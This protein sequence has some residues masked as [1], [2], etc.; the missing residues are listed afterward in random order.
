[1]LK[2]N[3][4]CDH[5]LIVLGSGQH[6]IPKCAYKGRMDLVCVQIADGVTYIDDCAFEDCRFLS[7]IVI[8]SSVEHISETAFKNCGS[9]FWQIFHSSKVEFLGHSDC[10]PQMGCYRAWTEVSAQDW[11]WLLRDH[12]I[13]RVYFPEENWR[14]LTS[15]DWVNLLTAQPGFAVEC[16]VYAGWRLLDLEAWVELLGA[17]PLLSEFALKLKVW[18]QFSGLE[19]SRLL[20]ARACFH[21]ECCEYDGWKKIHEDVVKAKKNAFVRSQQKQAFNYEYD[22]WEEPECEE[23]DYGL[24]ERGWMA[25]SKNAELFG[26][27]SEQLNKEFWLYFLLDYPKEASFWCQFSGVWNTLDKDDFEFLIRRDE[28]FVNLM[29]T[30]ESMG[31]WWRMYRIAP[32]VF[33]MIATRAT[34]ESKWRF[35]LPYIFIVNP[36][37]VSNCIAAPEMSGD[38]W[39]LILGFTPNFFKDVGRRMCGKLWVSLIAVANFD[40]VGICDECK[41]WQKLTTSDWKKLFRCRDINTMKKMH[42]TD[43]YIDYCADKGEDGMEKEEKIAKRLEGIF[44]VLIDR[45]DMY[46][47]WPRFNVSDWV[48]LLSAEPRLSEKCGALQELRGSDWRVILQEQPKMGTA[49][50]A[51]DGWRWFHEYDWMELLSMRNEFLGK[52]LRYG[53]KYGW[54]SM[55]EVKKAVRRNV[56]IME[57][58]RYSDDDRFDET[59]EEASGWIDTYGPGVNPS[60]IIEY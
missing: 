37:A 18:E 57:S 9:I 32:E 28:G 34:K 54:H 8:P 46:D 17:Q 53:A 26:R 41:G 12:P 16:D 11:T 24:D 14:Y 13:L 45:G 35:F 21:R 44:D 15:E 20:M 31:F 30:R 10:P 5:E 50:D 49:C 23:P 22:Y 19:W 55:E 39:S 38:D 25:L 29:T 48:E 2:R 59:W 58:L 33:Q 6:T 60:D 27:Y 3:F 1:M 7:V 36:S 40:V 51:V 56:E 43:Y 52:C 47:V 4:D 42:N